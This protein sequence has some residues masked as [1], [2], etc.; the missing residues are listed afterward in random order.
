MT[1]L[2]RSQAP[3]CYEAPGSAGW[4]YILP[5]V[6]VVTGW[7]GSYWYFS[8]SLKSTAGRVSAGVLWACVGTYRTL[9]SQENDTSKWKKSQLGPEKGAGVCRA[10][11][12]HA[13]GQR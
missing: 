9:H 8:C 4:R 6:R 1:Q 11:E 13:T 2:T 12:E 3:E 10:C 5:V 7:V